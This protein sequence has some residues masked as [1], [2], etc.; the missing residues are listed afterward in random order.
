MK[1]PLNDFVEI[2]QEVHIDLIPLSLEPLKN[3]S[4][5]RFRT[6][7]NSARFNMYKIFGVWKN[8]FLSFVIFDTKNKHRHYW[9][10][11]PFKCQTY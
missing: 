11:S 6:R 7:V 5:K 10:K 4:R 9:R 1:K 2:T 8:A 3:Y